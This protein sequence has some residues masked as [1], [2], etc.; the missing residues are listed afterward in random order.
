MID[1]KKKKK[2]LKHVRKFMGLTPEEIFEIDKVFRLF[3]KDQSGN[4]DA[5]ELKDAMTALGIY[6]DKDSLKKLMN[7]A[8][9]DGSGTIEEKEF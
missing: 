9:K 6:T 5:N 4:I 2:I 8:D 7:K 3:D 1:G